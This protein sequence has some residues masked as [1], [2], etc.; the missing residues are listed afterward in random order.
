MIIPQ[1]AAAETGIVEVTWPLFWLCL[2]M[3]GVSTALLSAVHRLSAQSLSLVS[4]G[5]VLLSALIMAIAEVLIV[6]QD[7]QD[8]SGVSGICLWIILFPLVIASRPKATLLTALSCASFMPLMY[9]IIPNGSGSHL[10]YLL[11]WFVPGYFCAGL[12]WLAS[13]SVSG[14]T[15]DL[16]QAQKEIKE[17]S[18]YALV[19]KLTQGGMGE[20][21]IARHRLLDQQAVM[22][23]INLDNNSFQAED[24]EQQFLKEAQ[25]L[26]KLRSPYV[27]R[28]YDYGLTETG[29]CYLLMEYIDG[30]SLQQ[31]IDSCGP[32]AVPRAVHILRDLARSLMAIHAVNMLHR[33]V[34]PDNV[35]LS[36]VAGVGDH[37][38]LIDFG[39]ADQQQT[40]EME[41]GVAG[42]MGYL[43]PE[44]LL[45]SAEPSVASDLYS[46][47]CVA[48]ALLTGKE[49]YAEAVDPAVAHIA[50]PLPILPDHVPAELTQIIHACLAKHPE[51]R[52]RSAAEVL[53]NLQELAQKMSWSPE[54]AEQWWQ[55]LDED[56]QL[57]RRKLSST[58]NKRPTMITVHRHGTV[59]RQ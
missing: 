41:D 12:S 16:Q 51:E 7:H 56:I 18:G 22:K 40:Q 53:A 30:F 50:G 8:I 15:D 31:L 55:V 14:L 5:Y 48:V 27:V 44:L 58:G 47:G 25:A 26:A 4:H 29:R 59:A 21:W 35:M 9:L 42:T 33:D 19:H 49:M 24:L 6:P 3:I 28:I 2:V 36:L 57:S 10:G 54:Q 1:L 20:V 11:E 39:L 23:F 32:F 37:V 46:F 13:R 43:A 52:T 38:T 34:K 45:G 17:L